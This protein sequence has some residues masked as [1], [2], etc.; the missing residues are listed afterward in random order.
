MSGIQ[1]REYQARDVEA[2]RAAYRAGCSAPLYVL[3]TG[4]G[5]TFAFSYIARQAAGKGHRVLILVHRQ[6]LLFQASRSLDALG[7]D[8][9]LIAPGQ[10]MT[11]DLVQVASVQTLARRLDKILAPDLIVIDEGHHTNAAT[12]AKIVGHFEGV[13]LLGVTA[14]PCRT[15]GSGLGKQAG[16]FFDVMV[17]GPTIRELIDQGF[18]SPPRVYAPP[19]GLD[20]SGVKTRFGDY[21]KKDVAEAMD[22]PKIT[23]NAV[24]HYLKL[25]PGVPALAFCSSVAHAEHVAEEFRAAGVSA[26][27]IDGTLHDGERKGLIHSLST[28]RLKVLT[29]CDIISEGTDIPVVGAAILLRPTHSLALFLQQIGRALRPYEGKECAVILDHVG[30]CLRH[31]MPDEDRVWSLDGKIKQGKGSKTA[32]EAERVKQ[33]DKCYGVHAPAPVCPHC[34]NVYE[35]KARGPEE[36]EGELEELG[37]FEAE[38]QRRFQRRERGWRIS[39]AQTL[40]DLKELGREWGYKPGW[41]RIQWQRKQQR[42]GGA[43]CLTASRA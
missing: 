17:Q 2:L 29:S 30:N 8:H 36:V 43:V 5:K 13:P 28:G 12:W 15:D 7:V 25:C 37:D 14:T 35:V 38:R 42:N 3:P 22:K 1:L 4:G 23:G 39:S 20:L 32:E 21:A 31:G 10:H 6:E 41:A 11:V 26:A 9:G 40:E 18:L 16:G 19:S 27:S 34:G 33:C 24:E